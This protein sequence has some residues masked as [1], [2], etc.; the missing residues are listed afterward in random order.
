MCSLNP[1]VNAA[2]RRQ[3]DGRARLLHAR[4]AHVV[5]I[6]LEGVVGQHSRGWTR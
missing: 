4:L 2:D 6:H 1:K 5:V 3:T